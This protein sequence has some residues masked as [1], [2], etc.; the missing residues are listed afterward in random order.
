MHSRTT[1]I[2]AATLACAAALGCATR[3]VAQTEQ[4]GRF[5]YTIGVDLEH[6]TNINLSESDPIS[7]DVLMPNFAFTYVQRGSVL[8]ANASGTIQYRD[9]L[10]GEFSDEV[11]GAVSG[12]FDWHISPDRFDW[13]LEDYVG[14]QPVNVLVND[15]PSNQQQTNVFVTGP[16]LRAHFSDQLR[17][18]LDLRYTNSYA[19]ETRD[20]N[21]DR[22]GAVGRLIDLLSPA[23]TIS[24]NVGL[25][26][27]RYDNTGD[28]SDY[29][30]GDAY[31]TYIRTAANGRLQIDA[32]YTWLDFKGGAESHSGAL[33]RAIGRYDF[34]NRL[35]TTLNVTHQLSDAIDILQVDP[36]QVNMV[37]IGSGLSGALIS[38][39]VYRED[40]VSL[41]GDYRA[42]TNSFHLAPFWYK[43]NYINNDIVSITTGVNL[44]AYGIYGSYE[45]RLRPDWTLGAFA[46]VEY[47]RYTDFDRH[48]DVYDYGARLAWQI[49][50]HWASH[51]VLSRELQSTNAANLSYNGNTISVGVTYS[52]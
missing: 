43:D 15:T 30:R 28:A 52:R 27:V 2:A 29:D 26:A 8:E 48:D 50:A 13:M 3:A 12:V 18:Q 38:P 34:D 44:R 11:R 23:N 46:G 16:T 42:E 1:A 9:Y 33:L 24:G 20:F 14:R 7:E 36:T 45:Y 49:A 4:P 31:G 21:G 19:D 17:G 6:D 40:R 5:E 22:F 41:S 51:L 10:G 32:G 25:Q 47:R 35:S 39:S 37:V